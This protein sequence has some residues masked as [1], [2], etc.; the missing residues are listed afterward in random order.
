MSLMAKLAQSTFES[1]EGIRENNRKTS[2]QFN[3]FVAGFQPSFDVRG[4]RVW[5]NFGIAIGVL[6]AAVFF[7]WLALVFTNLTNKDAMIMTEIQ[8]LGVHFIVLSLG[9]VHLTQ[10]LHIAMREQARRAVPAASVSSVL[11]GIVSGFFDLVSVAKAFVILDRYS[12]MY[13][14]VACGE[15][16]TSIFVVIWAGAA[17]GWQARANGSESE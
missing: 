12:S 11:F 14:A 2:R 1:E 16:A 7:T 9:L 6:D 17:Y 3:K 15:L 8:L 4:G 5:R 13:K 10:S